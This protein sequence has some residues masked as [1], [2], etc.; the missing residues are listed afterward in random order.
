MKLRRYPRLVVNFD[1]TIHLQAIVESFNC[2]Y[3]LIR[4]GMGKDMNMISI[5]LCQGRDNVNPK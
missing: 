2:W 3:F 4:L 5:L 1:W